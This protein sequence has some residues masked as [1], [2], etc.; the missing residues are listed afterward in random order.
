[1]SAEKAAQVQKR[2]AE[3]SN[4]MG[5]KSA[6]ASGA[7]AKKETKGADVERFSFFQAKTA[8]QVHHQLRDLRNQGY[9]YSFK[10]AAMLPVMGACIWYGQYL[11][12]IFPGMYAGWSWALSKDRW[13][14]FSLRSQR[15]ALT[16]DMMVIHDDAEPIPFEGVHNAIDFVRPPFRSIFK[17]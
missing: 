7:P 15:P 1:M 13:Y 11:L 17:F 6:A 4:A 14:K 16:P 9:F 5:K 2:F 3:A 12:A 8:L 10:A